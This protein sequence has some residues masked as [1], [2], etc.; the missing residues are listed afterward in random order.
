MGHYC[1][2]CHLDA[3]VFMHLCVPHSSNDDRF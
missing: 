2:F 1:V 3:P